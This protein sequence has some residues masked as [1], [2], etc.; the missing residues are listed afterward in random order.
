M[1][2]I[3][4]FTTDRCAF[5]L[6]AKRLLDDRGLAYSEENVGDD[7]AKRKWLIETTGKRTVPQIFFGDRAIGGFDELAA[8]DRSGT[9]IEALQAAG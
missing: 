3:R 4:I 2:K 7:F 9:L 5:C 8:M 1:A 6:L